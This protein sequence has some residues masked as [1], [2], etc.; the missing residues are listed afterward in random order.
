M[1]S[2][3]IGSRIKGLRELRNLTQSELAA[4][5]HVQRQTVN[6]WENGTRDLKTDYTVKLAVFFGTTCDYILRGIDALNVTA[7]DEFG[8]SDDAL[9]ALR[10]LNETK[11]NQPDSVHS[12]LNFLL[13]NMSVL[14]HNVIGCIR[15]YLSS[16]FETV[17]T[18]ELLDMIEHSMLSLPFGMSAALDSIIVREKSTGNLTSFPAEMLN[19]IYI[20][21]I[22]NTLLLLK[23][24]WSSTR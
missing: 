11:L 5:L 17:W 12:T 24:K 15:N 20:I 19:A 18:N 10:Y 23:E 14:S 21:Q 9:D 6:Q 1:T 3:T 4:A 2:N 13:E 8:L 22:Q 7:Y 16:G